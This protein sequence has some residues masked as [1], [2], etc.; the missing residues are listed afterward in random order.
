[1]TWRDAQ[2]GE[3]WCSEKPFPWAK[4]VAREGC[5]A[6]NVLELRGVDGGDVY[7]YDSGTLTLVGSR[8][9]GMGDSW[10]RGRVPVLDLQCRSERVVCDHRYP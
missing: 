6:F 1:M 3:P 4:V 7:Y 9:F 8:T 5:G 2:A 10:C